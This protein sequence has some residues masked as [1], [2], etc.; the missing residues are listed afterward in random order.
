MRQPIFVEEYSAKY[1]NLHAGQPLPDTARGT[2]SFEKYSSNIPNSN[3]NPYAPFANKMNW[4]IAKWA[5]LRGPGSN[6]LAELL[7]VEG[8]SNYI[9]VYRYI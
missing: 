6:S 5:K 3:D 9:S 8:V 7:A 4:D 1:P 2:T